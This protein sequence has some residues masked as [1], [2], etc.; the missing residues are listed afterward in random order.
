MGQ[1]PDEK[2][3]PPSGSGRLGKQPPREQQGYESAQRTSAPDSAAE[4]CT[5][6][7]FAPVSRWFAS[8][9]QN[10]PREMAGRL[11]WGER[12]FRQQCRRR[13]VEARQLRE[14]P[15]AALPHDASATIL[16]R[17]G[18][19]SC[20]ARRTAQRS[21][22]KSPDYQA[23]RARKSGRGTANSLPLLMPGFRANFSSAVSTIWSSETTFTTWST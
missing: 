14:P 12:S 21:A 9:L 11:R 1:S 19:A 20:G 4:L 23:Y 18:P 2:R 15:K 16:R 7:L 8:C 3:P 10:W 6:A 22:A 13:L 17:L 5:A